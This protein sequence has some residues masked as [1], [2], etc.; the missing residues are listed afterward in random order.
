ML[1]AAGIVSTAVPDCAGAPS[2]SPPATVNVDVAG[3]KVAGPDGR[4]RTI[5]IN[6]DDHRAFPDAPMGFDVPQGGENTGH[7]E[8]VTYR[9]KTVG[10]TRKVTVY[11]PPGYTRDKKYPVLYLLHGIGGDETEWPHFGVPNVIID[12][13]LSSEKATPMII[14]MPN[15]RALP[16]DRVPP[17]LFSP[18]NI[19]GFA[20]FE[21]DLFDDLIPF[22]ESHYSVAAGRENRALAGLS[23]G[24]GQTLNFGLS[25]PGTFAWIGAFSPAPNTKAPDQLLA[26]VPDRGPTMK[27]IYLSC[28]S[29]DGLLGIAQGVHGYL[30]TQGI[31]HY[32]N[33]DDNAHD[34]PEWRNNFYHF[35]QLVFR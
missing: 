27:L 35:A 10:A 6:A 12:R 33:V 11:T 8:V 30:L 17:N 24:G 29:R 20:A 14:V 18:Q 32:W 28:G 16:D 34:T 25:H 4:Q 9:S 7:M 19:A 2:N 5:V 31:R 22:V 21:G 26:S 3:T 15:G 1:A 23:M 13:L